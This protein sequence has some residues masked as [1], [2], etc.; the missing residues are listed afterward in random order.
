[1]RRRT[2]AKSRGDGR[3]SLAVDLALGIA[4]MV[5]VGSARP[6][7]AGSSTGAAPAPP[8]QV[9]APSMMWMAPVV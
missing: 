1:M 7:R 4:P 3:R 8:Q 6:P 5:R 9:S 2:R